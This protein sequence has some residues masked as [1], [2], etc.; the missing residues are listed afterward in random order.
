MAGLYSHRASGSGKSSMYTSA[1]P[2]ESKK[3][4]ASMKSSS[5]PQKRKHTPSSQ[6]EALVSGKR[7]RKQWPQESLVREPPRHHELVPIAANPVNASAAPPGPW[8]RRFSSFAFA[9]DAR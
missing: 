3:P 6:E 8:N 2:P 1:K 4:A 5:P 9:T 7:Q